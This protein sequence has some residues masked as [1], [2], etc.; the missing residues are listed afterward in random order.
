MSYRKA[1]D[2]ATK[3]LASEKEAGMNLAPRVKAM[4]EAGKIAVDLADWADRVRSLGNE[5]NHEA[6]EP[7]KEDIDDLANFTEMTLVYLF[8][9][10][11]RV[12]LKRERKED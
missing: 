9:M 7:S 6:G 2:I 1:L 8:E 5:A 4:K 11:E 10:P 12:R 3:A